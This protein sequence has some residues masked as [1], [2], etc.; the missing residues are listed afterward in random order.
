MD[1]IGFAK[2]AF[3]WSMYFI[4]MICLFLAHCVHLAVVDIMYKKPLVPEDDE[5]PEDISSQADNTQAVNSQEDE[6]E[7][8]EDVQ[9]S[10]PFR[11]EE[12]P[13]DAVLPDLSD[14]YR[15][16]VKNIRFIVKYFR[17]ERN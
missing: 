12:Y 11:L 17:H 9:M 2:I 8:D 6:T 3:K 5:D 15:E 13:A 16:A 4:K 1:L 14:S 10:E 7:A